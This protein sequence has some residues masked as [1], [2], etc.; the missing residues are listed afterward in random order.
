M[1]HLSVVDVVHSK[2]SGT[3]ARP[4]G[5]LLMPIVIFGAMFL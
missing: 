2:D 4:F 1:D 3:T 5:E